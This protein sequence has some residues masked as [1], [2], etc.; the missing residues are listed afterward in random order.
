[1]SSKGDDIPGRGGLPFRRRHT[2][3]R[4]RRGAH[5]LLLVVDGGIALAGED[6]TVSGLIA[7]W[8]KGC[9]LQRAFNSPLTRPRQ[10]GAP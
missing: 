10:I 8:L 5:D 3:S 9:R 4:K 6:A 7:R 1:M 2:G